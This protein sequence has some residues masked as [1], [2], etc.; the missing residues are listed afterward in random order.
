MGIDLQLLQND[1][2]GDFEGVCASQK[3]RFASEEL[4][5]EVLAMYKEWTKSAFS[6]AGIGC[7]RR[8]KTDEPLL[9]LCS[10]IRHPA[11]AEGGQ[12]DPEGHRRLHEGESV[13]SQSFFRPS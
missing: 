12:Q 13:A 5:H 9:T 7:K 11:V 2:G 6:P 10:P 1:K 8:K 4:V 3:K